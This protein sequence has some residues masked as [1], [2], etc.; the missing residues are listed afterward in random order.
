M[1]FQGEIIL[2]FVPL[3][4][5]PLHSNLRTPCSQNGK[6]KAASIQSRSMQLVLLAFC[7]SFPQRCHPVNVQGSD[8]RREDAAVH[9]PGKSIPAAVLPLG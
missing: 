1:T 4:H 3:G 9:W 8:P 6:K 2:R 5:R 7:G